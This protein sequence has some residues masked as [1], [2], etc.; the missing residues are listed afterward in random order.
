MELLRRHPSTLAQKTGLR[1]VITGH[2]LEGA[3]AQQI[4]YAFPPARFSVEEYPSLKVAKVV[5]FDSS[6]VNGWVSVDETLR[7]RN[8][9]GLEVTRA[10][11]H[12]EGLAYL[13]LLLS[14]FDS[15]SNGRCDA[16]GK[17]CSEPKFREVRYRVG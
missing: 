6:P 4:A 5:V 3:I 7:M 13:R 14:Y 1:I 11:Q 16:H 9:G 8:A 12:G 15:V 10:F 2:S 17:S